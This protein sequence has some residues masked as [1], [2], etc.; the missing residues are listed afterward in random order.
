MSTYEREQVEAAIRAKEARIAELR[1]ERYRALD[2]GDTWG[3]MKANAQIQLE[4]P[5]LSELYDRRRQLIPAGEQP[6]MQSSG[7]IFSTLQAPDRPRRSEGGA[8]LSVAEA[9][10]CEQIGMS[11]EE[12]L[13]RKARHQKG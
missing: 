3:G 12:F 6:G 2:G 10:A 13:R 7:Q 11:A 8:T 9:E 1:A 5:A 4:N